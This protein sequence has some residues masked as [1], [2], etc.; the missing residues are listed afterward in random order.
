M[1]HHKSTRG[2]ILTMEINLAIV[3]A[4]VLIIRACRGL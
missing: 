3:I 4:T 1:T 2:G